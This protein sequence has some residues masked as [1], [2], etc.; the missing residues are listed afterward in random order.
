VIVYKI[1]GL[2]CRLAGDR[3]G[4]HTVEVALALVLFA[5]V[6]GG[7]FYGYGES[8]NASYRGLA[9]TLDQSPSDPLAPIRDGGAGATQPGS[10]GG[11]GT[12]DG[13]SGGGSGGT[14][15][16]GATG[17]SGGGSGG[18]TVVAGGDT[19]SS[20]AASGQTV[21][22]TAGTAGSASGAIVGGAGQAGSNGAA[23]NTSGGTGG[24]GA[25]AG[26]GGG[27]GGGDGSL[28]LAS[29][30][31]ESGISMVSAS[32]QAAAPGEA[33]SSVTANSG[34]I[35]SDASKA[36][37]EGRGNPLWLIL[38]AVGLV[39]LA[40]SGYLLYRGHARRKETGET[41]QIHRMTPG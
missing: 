16:D 37:A 9:D 23:G 25:G 39:G 15:G 13:G 30:S 26:A 27:A 18:G 1:A 31:G 36:I 19:G 7:S 21:A 35:L 29:L 33:K 11:V 5:F 20:G 41:A 4:V 3:R 8:L 28:V 12:A 2:L 38:I 22:S 6:A 34:Q 40:I 32:G 10:G 24:G 14:A 17:G